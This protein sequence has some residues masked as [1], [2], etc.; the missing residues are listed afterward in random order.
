LGIVVPSY[1]HG[2]KWFPRVKPFPYSNVKMDDQSFEINGVI[3]RNV[4][5]VN[6][7]KVDGCF[8]T[9]AAIATNAGQSGECILYREPCSDRCVV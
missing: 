8:R 3:I 4:T 6:W 9:R 1:L 5:F 7:T 2:P